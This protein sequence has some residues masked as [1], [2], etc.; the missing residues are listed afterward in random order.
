MLYEMKSII[1][2]LE[3]VYISTT[4]ITELGLILKWDLH[5]TVVISLK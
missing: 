3:Y 1:M 5:L 4:V 2:R